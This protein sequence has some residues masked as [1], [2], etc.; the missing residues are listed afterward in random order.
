M[1]RSQC[2]LVRVTAVMM[3]YHDQKQVGEESVSFLWLTLSHCS[4]SSKKIRVGTQAGR[5]L[6]VGADAESTE[7]CYL[8]LLACSSW[9]P[10]RNQDYQPRD[11]TICISPFESLRESFSPH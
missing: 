8:L 11:D 6:K 7:G 4:L 2:V 9:H 5:N 3:K 10:C 1:P